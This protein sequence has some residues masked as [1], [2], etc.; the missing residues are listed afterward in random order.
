VKKTGFGGFDRD[1]LEKSIA[2]VAEAFEV[3][4][5]PTPDQLATNKF[6]PPQEMRMP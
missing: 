5:P 4:N 1:R 3:K 6:L 2:G